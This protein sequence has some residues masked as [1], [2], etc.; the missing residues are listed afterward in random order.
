MA[1]SRHGDGGMEAGGPSGA[2]GARIGG[3]RSACRDSRK[4][5]S[6]RLKSA[7]PVQEHARVSDE[8]GSTPVGMGSSTKLYRSDIQI[9]RLRGNMVRELG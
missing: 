9:I 2:R 7:A 5:V 1:E 4:G 8:H 6:S 3:G